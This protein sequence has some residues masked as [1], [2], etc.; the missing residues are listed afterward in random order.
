M[1][2]VEAVEFAGV[3]TIPKLLVKENGKYSH[4]PIRVGVTRID[5][6]KTEEE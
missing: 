1:V 6:I 3:G 5:D 2:D 4:I